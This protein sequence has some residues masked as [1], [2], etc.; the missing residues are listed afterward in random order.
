MVK[1]SQK[2]NL[3]SIQVLKTF[4]VLLRGNYAMNELIK[5]LNKDEEAPVFNNSTISKYIN[6]CRY[7]G[8]DIPKINNKY[9]VA[10]LPFGLKLSSSDAD[11]VEM[12]QATVKNDSTSTNANLFDKFLAKLNAY[13]DK[14]I[15]RVEKKIFKTSFELFERA[16]ARKRKIR[17]FFK[18]QTILEGIPVEIKENKDKTFFHVFN[19][20]L[21][22]IDSSR[23]SGVEITDSKYNETFN[24]EQ[25]TIYV[26]KGALAKRY[27]PRENESLEANNDGTVTVT[28]RN[29]NK[30]ILFSRLLRYEDS[31]EIIKPKVYRE[32]F[33]QLIQNTL[34]N[35]GVS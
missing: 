3:S 28:N 19:K 10:G 13:S 34:K 31:C 26:L 11:M 30:D 20:R 14:N 6:T 7:I 33:K 12:L 16:I 8:I 5:L 1:M 32:E 35:Y 21:R 24:G 17:L 9:Y 25:V 15:A 23:L 22:I 4:G 2:I 27:E 18:N 29:E